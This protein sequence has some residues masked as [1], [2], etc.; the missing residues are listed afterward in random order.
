MRRGEVRVSL[1]SLSL[2]LGASLATAVH[3]LSS[4]SHQATLPVGPR[5][6]RAATTVASCLCLPSCRMRVPS[7][8]FQF[9]VAC[10]LLWLFKETYFSFVFCHIKS[11]LLN[12]P[13]SSTCLIGLYVCNTGCH[14]FC[15]LVMLFKLV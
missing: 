12:E 14:W 15:K 13:G 7:Y 3:P 4:S 2:L 8:S 6:L 5:C 1:P 10:W 9:P 11:P